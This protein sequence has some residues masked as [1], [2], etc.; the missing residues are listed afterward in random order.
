MEITGLD[1]FA[2]SF[3]KF[4]D[5]YVLIGGSACYLNLDNAGID[6][7]ATKDLDI[8]LIINVR[9]I[10]NDFLDAIWKFIEAGEYKIRNRGN[11]KPIFYR[12]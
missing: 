6:F 8:V 1:L 5:Q 12:F 2:K 11:R 10:D 7:R 3:E 4:K 9:S